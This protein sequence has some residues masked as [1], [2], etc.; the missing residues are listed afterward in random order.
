[1]SSKASQAKLVEYLAAENPE[2]L[3][4][5]VHPGVIDTAM[6]RKSELDSLPKDTG[7]HSFQ[8]SANDCSVLIRRP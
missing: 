5:S 4:C 7:M 6:L 3:F 1:M 2:V 8:I